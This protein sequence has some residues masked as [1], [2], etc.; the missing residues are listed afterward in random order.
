MPRALNRVCAHP[1]Q[2]SW[3]VGASILNAIVLAVPSEGVRL[4]SIA[5]DW[6]GWASLVLAVSAATGLGYFLGMFICWPWIRPLCSRLNGA[7]FKCG[8]HVV[9]L[10]GPLR[11]TSAVV[12][13][14]TKS[15]GAWDVVWLDL[16]PERG[17]RFRNTFEEHSITKCRK[18]G[19]APNNAPRSQLPTSPEKRSPDLLR[20]SSFGGCG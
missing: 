15:Q 16:G 1:I 17:R 18:G 19:G 13:D 8:G 9:I 4:V 2:I 5:L 12:E 20:T 11:G 3:M 14:I 10:T 7:P 6:Q